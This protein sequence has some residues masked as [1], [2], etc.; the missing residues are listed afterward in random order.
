[1]TDVTDRLLAGVAAIVAWM[2]SFAFVAATLGGLAVLLG[3]RQFQGLW[4]LA[5]LLLIGGCC[6][7]ASVWAHG[8]VTAAHRRERGAGRGGALGCLEGDQD[9]PGDDGIAGAALAV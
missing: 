5:I 4:F 3:T 6:S 2:L 9:V 8:R 1:M 7:L